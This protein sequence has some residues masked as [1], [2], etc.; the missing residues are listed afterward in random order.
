MAQASEFLARG[1][2]PALGT[3]RSGPLSGLRDFFQFLR[4]ELRPYPG[5]GQTVLR[6]VLCAVLADIL[7][8]TLRV[9]FPSYSAYIVFFLANEDSASSIKIGLLAMI[10][11]TITVATAAWISICFMDAPWFRV[12]VTIALIGG[13]VW[14][15]R[16][17]VGVLMAVI[18]S[19]YLSLADTISD[20]EQLTEATLWLWP[21]V[22]IAV[23]VS[24]VMSVVLEPRPDLLLRAQIE[25]DWKKSAGARRAGFRARRPAR[26]GNSAAPPILRRAAAHAATADTVASA[27]VA[28]DLC[29]T[30]LGARHFHHRAAVLGH[31]GAGRA[32]ALRCE[33]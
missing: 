28:E 30:R 13:A 15:S 2:T 16:T 1:L 29:G 12:P 23:G 19:L 7:S 4:E 21:V 22:G 8:Q 18:L 5:R 9:P 25:A 32:G 10:G 11:I 31:R 33:Q 26:P 27:G 6:L 20:A 3:E 14:L 24:T 17:L